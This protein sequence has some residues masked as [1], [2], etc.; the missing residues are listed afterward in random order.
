MVFEEF[1]TA[2]LRM[3][4]Q[5]ALADILL[6]FWVQLH[7]LTPNTIMQLSKYFWA[8]MSFGGTPTSDGFAKRYELHYQPKKMEADGAI[9][10]TQF[11]YL[12]F[13]GEWGEAHHC[14]EKQ[15][16]GRL[17]EGLVLLQGSSACLPS[18]RKKHTHFALSHECARV[19]DGAS[20]RFPNTNV[21]D[22]AFVKATS[23]IEGHDDVEV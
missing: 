3:P 17:D 15:L 21:G 2:G 11:S 20:D 4:P 13:H 12:N 10:D 7:Q 23:A 5:P 18:R 8:V 14:H 16:G 1:F 22:V 6:K 19:F 9:L